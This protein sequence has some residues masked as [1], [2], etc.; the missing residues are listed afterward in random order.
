MKGMFI[1]IFALFCAELCIAQTT[2][3]KTTDSYGSLTTFSNGITARK[4]TDSYGS[5]TTFSNG[6]T[7]RKTTDSYGSLTTFSNELRHTQ[8]P[9]R[10]VP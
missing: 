7:A 6:I 5:L 8:L 2:A 9:I 1:V 10:L 3:R 4:T